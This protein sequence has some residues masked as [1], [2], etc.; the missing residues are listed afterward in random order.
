MKNMRDFFLRNKKIFIC[1]A[2]VLI[3]IFNGILVKVLYN[4]TNP[5][6]KV[7]YL[8][9]EF[10][11]AP[12]DSE[13]DEVPS[14]AE[15]QKIENFKRGN[16]PGKEKQNSFVWVKIEFQIPEEYKNKELGLV[17]PYLSLAE[18]AWLN[19]QFAGSYGKFPPNE[20]TAHFQAHYFLLPQKDLNQNGKNIFLMKVFVQGKGAISNKIFIS[21]S[22]YAFQ[23]ANDITFMNSKVYMMFVGGMFSAFL[24]FLSIF[25]FNK[26]C[27]EYL[28][29][30]MMNLC[31]IGFILSFFASD[32]PLYTSMCIPN[33]IFFKFSFCI[34]ALLSVFFTSSF[35]VSFFGEKENSVV[36]KIRIVLLLVEVFLIASSSDFWQLQASIK[37]CLVLC[38]LSMIYGICFPFR[39]IFQKENRKNAIILMIAFFPS[40]CSFLFDFVNKFIL[41]DLLLPFT[42]VFG[43]QITIVIFLLL[44]GYQYGKLHLNAE[45]AN[46][47]LEDEIRKK[48]Q[49]LIEINSQLETERSKTSIELDLASSMQKKILP[50]PEKSFMGWDVAILYEPLQKVS[51]D[52]YDYFDLNG[53]LNGLS[54]FDISGHGI[55]ASMI[56]VMAKNVIRRNFL[57]G[58]ALEESPSKILSKISREIAEEKGEVDNY[59]TGIILT[60]DSFSRT[61]ECEV[62]IANGGHPYPILY[63]A[64]QEKAEEILPDNLEN[65]FGAIGIKDFDTS[66]PTV[67]FF[68]AIDDVLVLF[69]DGV[70]ES[71]NVM[72]IQFGK[73]R[74]KAAIVENASKSPKEI[75]LAIRES[76]RE[77]MKPLEVND[78]ITI[79]VMKRES[80]SDFIEEI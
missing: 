69:T 47:T 68:M 10:Y 11:W 37:V 6:E 18:K 2:L 5:S 65:Q 45:K 72:K 1:V 40:V 15:F 76:L 66:F 3:N 29:F 14:N 33:L 31:S 36:F 22:E 62:H 41:G 4:F 42:S 9:Q 46:I 26:K 20:S 35:L 52:L 43:W 28:D 77:Y 73:H 57:R 59:L 75:A 25:L 55:S 58:H 64:S 54:L 49:R 74:L 34:C 79:V 60:I 19:G 12:S 78:D 16:L 48:T 32:L 56:S 53:K 51:G 70:T 17:I 38:V 8:P 7:Y 61:D 27:R 24:I 80:S 50:K 44:L 71:E 63:R 21:D 67:D 23:R 39:K 13:S 30:S